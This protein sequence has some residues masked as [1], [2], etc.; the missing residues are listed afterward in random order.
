MHPETL[1]GKAAAKCYNGVNY[2]RSLRDAMGNGHHSVAEHA[3]FTFEIDGVSRVLL[4]QLTRHRVASFS[5]Q[6][7]RYCGANMD[8]VVPDSMACADL[9]DEIIEVKKAVRKLYDKAT[10]IGVP[11][12]DA[13]YFTLQGGKTNLLVTMNARELL[14]FFELRC[15]N[16]AQWEIRGVAWQMLEECKRVAP[17]LF[18]DAGPGCLRGA[19]PEKRPCGRPYKKEGQNADEGTT[20]CAAKKAGEQAGD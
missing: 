1:A 7:Q 5:V 19:C 3:T 11:A 16:R 2:E 20:P 17:R 14:H 9:L 6:S 15:C 8:L 10:G 13:R 18:K 4:A 12:E